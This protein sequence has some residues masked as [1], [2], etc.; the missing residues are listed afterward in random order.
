ME[1]WRFGGSVGSAS[2]SVFADAGAML[3]TLTPLRLFFLK[4]GGDEL[5]AAND[6]YFDC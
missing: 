1:V 3:D 4:L 6:D 2:D 5:L